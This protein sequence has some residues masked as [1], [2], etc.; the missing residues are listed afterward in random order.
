M[1]AEKDAEIARLKAIRKVHVEAIE[2]MEAGL[3][4]NEKNSAATSTSGALRWRGGVNVS[5]L[6]PLITESLEKSGNFTTSGT[7]VGSRLPSSSRTRR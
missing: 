4:E 2:S 3:Q 6:M 7:G 5:V 1:I